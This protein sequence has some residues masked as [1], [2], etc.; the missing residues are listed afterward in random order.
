MSEFDPSREPAPQL[1]P[2]QQAVANLTSLAQWTIDW[3]AKNHQAK[4]TEY[5][6]DI[7]FRE[8]GT[9]GLMKGP[10]IREI[11]RGDQ[12]RSYAM[13][14]PDDLHMGTYFCRWDAGNAHVNVT[15]Q[16]D[17]LNEAKP[18]VCRELGEI[19]DLINL[20][21]KGLAPLLKD[22]PVPNRFLR[23]LFR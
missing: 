11:N 7:T 21:R 5:Y 9:D 15:Y 20:A 23:L 19:N 4:V 12:H 18:G 17:F 22:R 16:S 8:V 13:A 10:H 6:G 3:Q 2:E 14:W 1:T